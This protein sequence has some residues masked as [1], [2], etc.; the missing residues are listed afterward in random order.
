VA[1]FFEMQGK[2][3][4]CAGAMLLKRL[5]STEGY[6]GFDLDYRVYARGVDP[7]RLLIAR[8][9]C[10]YTEYVTD[11]FKEVSAAVRDLLGSRE[12]SEVL[13][14]IRSSDY[15]LVALVKAAKNEGPERV[16]YCYLRASWFEGDAGSSAAEEMF[17]GKARTCFEDLLAARDVPYLDESIRQRTC[18]MLAEINRRLGDFAKAEEHL[19]QADTLE[20]AVLVRDQRN[21]IRKKD[22]LRRRAKS[23]H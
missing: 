11:F 20:F 15:P 1:D 4:V 2:C 10:S 16:A 22:R 21:L 6:T 5:K 3:P 12:Y 13:N 7:V 23:S 9:D 8:C 14:T 17:L 19:S 18:Y